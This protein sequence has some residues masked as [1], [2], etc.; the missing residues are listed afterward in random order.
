LIENRLSELYEQF[1]VS[2]PEQFLTSIAFMQLNIN[3]IPEFVCTFEK[4]FAEQ[5]PFFINKA[6]KIYN[7]VAVEA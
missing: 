3:K 7:F 1:P 2:S 4:F 5:S 6:Q